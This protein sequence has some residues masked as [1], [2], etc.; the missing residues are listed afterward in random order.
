MSEPHWEWYRSF[1]QVLE[2]GSLSAAGRAMGVAQ[3]TVGRHIDGL[4]SALGLQLFTRSSDGFA[5]TEA[6]YEL[7]PYAASMAAT[8]AAVP[9]CE[10]MNLTAVTVGWT[11]LPKPPSIAP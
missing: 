3:P 10:L 9:Q 11:S 6:A 8:A 2:S 5:P 4:E 7:Q 1:L